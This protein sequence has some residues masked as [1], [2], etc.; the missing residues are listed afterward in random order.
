MH[1]VITGASGRI[2]RQLT[3]EL[4]D[5]HQLR[6]LDR[7]RLPRRLTPRT[8]LA[9]R[10]AWL[11]WLPGPYTLTPWWER[12]F[13][14]ADVVVHLAA[15]PRPGAP[16]KSVL[17]NN[18]A[19]TWNV[20]EVA[21]KHQVPRVVFASS[22]WTVKALEQ[23]LAPDCYCPDGPKIGSEA[24]A[25]PVSLYGISKAFGEQLGR[26][27]VDAG[28]FR[29][30]V[31]VRLGGYV[32]FPERKKRLNRLWI[33]P[34]DLRSLLRRCVEVEFDG[35]HIVYGVSSESTAP[36]DLSYTRALLQWTP[37]GSSGVSLAGETEPGCVAMGA[38]PSEETVA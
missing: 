35:Y 26:A 12:A 5:A 16:L 25:K 1:V 20:F 27:Y 24:L 30:F 38:R 17:R 31:A 32:Q 21:A 23:E 6:L 3:E 7:H 28:R 9:V 4:S 2:G 19:A 15:D 11:R 18:V 22:N 13:E 36:Y 29:S 10:L 33:G 37:E 34:R 8:D 14:G